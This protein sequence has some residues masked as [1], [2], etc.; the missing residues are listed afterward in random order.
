[1]AAIMVSLDWLFR[2]FQDTTSTAKNKKTNEHPCQPI[3]VLYPCFCRIKIVLVQDRRDH[4]KFF[5]RFPSNQK[6]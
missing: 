4:S 1:M 3:N 5:L 2:N 6:C